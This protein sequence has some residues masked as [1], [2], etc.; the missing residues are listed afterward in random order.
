MYI[1][2]IVKKWIEIYIQISPIFH[3]T[4]EGGEA[5]ILV[6][7][8]SILR[9]IRC[10]RGKLKK[11]KKNKGGGDDLEV[12]TVDIL[13]IQIVTSLMRVCT[14]EK[15]SERERGD[16]CIRVCVCVCVHVCAR[17]YTSSTNILYITY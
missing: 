12:L 6:W 11:L 4:L 8:K 16:V 14:R 2:F 1:Q 7:R 10:K 5:I 15:R 9:C 17:I 13:Y 3:L